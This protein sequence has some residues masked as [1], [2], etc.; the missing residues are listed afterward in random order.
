MFYQKVRGFP[1]EYNQSVAPVGPNMPPPIKKETWVSGKQ[2]GQAGSL[3]YQQ[4]GSKYGT[5][6]VSGQE[7][8]PSNQS[9]LE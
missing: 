9:K 7:A 1:P 6:L 8:R 5:R 2:E 3:L 4:L